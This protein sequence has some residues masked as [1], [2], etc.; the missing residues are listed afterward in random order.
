MGMLHWARERLMR[1]VE[2][3]PIARRSPAV[4]ANQ[5][6]VSMWPQQG[7]VHFVRLGKSEEVNQWL[8]QECLATERLTDSDG[9]ENA[10]I[11]EQPFASH[12]A[13]GHGDFPHGRSLG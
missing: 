11:D 10:C 12:F 4:A 9:T 1:L 3:R 8:E 7:S 5:A 6:E 13:Y 2:G